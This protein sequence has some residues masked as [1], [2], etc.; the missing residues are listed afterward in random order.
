M[1]S[2]FL[3]SLILHVLQKKPLFLGGGGGFWRSL[4]HPNLAA[5]R[6]DRASDHARVCRVCHSEVCADEATYYLVFVLCSGGPLL[7]DGVS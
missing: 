2:V 3:A 1:R 4:G 7:E 6:E 5:L